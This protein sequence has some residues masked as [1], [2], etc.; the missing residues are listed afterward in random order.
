LGSK[1]MPPKSI[2]VEASALACAWTL[3]VVSVGT[4]WHV[5]Q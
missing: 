1:A 2:S 3:A 4:S 5:L